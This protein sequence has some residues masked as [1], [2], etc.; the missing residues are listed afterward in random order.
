[1]KKIL[2]S[3]LGLLCLCVIGYVSLNRQETTIVKENLAHVSVKNTHKQHLLS[4]PFSEV[5]KLSKKE[6]KAQGLP[7]NKYLERE[8]EL[9]MNPEIGRP[10]PENLGEI[11]KQIND[12][13]LEGNLQ[14]RVSGDGSDNNWVE[15][16]PDNVGGRTRAVMFDPNDA[17]NETVFAGGVSGGLWKNTNISSASSVWTQVSISENLNVS[18]IV[19]DPID[20]DIF[21]IG[22][23][24][25]YVGGDANGNGVWKSIDQ[26][27][28]W[29][30]VLGGITGATT[31]QAASVVTVNS[32]VGI[33]A[34]YAC[35]P[36][37]VANFGVAFTGTIPG[38]IVLVD[39]GN[40]PNEDACTA[41]T[42]GSLTGKIALI[43]RGTCAFVIKVKAAQEAGA[44]GAI[45]MNNISGTPIPMGGT[46]ATII[47]P[48]VMISK[49]DGDILEA[50]MAGG[51]VTVT[52]ALNEPSGDYTGN[53]V[54]GIQHI[55]DIVIR[56]NGGVSEI[57][58]AAGATYYS[59]ANAYMGGNTYGLYKSVDA[60]ANWTLLSMPL[61]VP[62]GKKHTPND[63]EIGADNRLWIGTTNTT[64]TGEGGGK[65]FVS[66]DAA[67]TTFEEK[68]AITN[69]AR[70]QI[71]TSP[72]NGGTVYVLAQVN[73]IN[74]AGT[75]Y[76]APF[77]NMVK[78]SN[79]FGSTT[80]MALPNG[81]STDA[82]DFTRGQAFYDLVIAV[83]PTNENN[84][85]VGG[86]DLFKSTNAGGSWSQFSSWYGGGF[87][88]V[89]SDQHAFAFGNGDVNKMLIGNDGGV[90]YSA[91]K[92]T[93]TAA[94]NSGFNVTQ[95]YTVGV[96]PSGASAGD[97]FSAG[98]QD[99]GT[100]QFDNVGPGIN[101]SSE[102]QGGDGAGTDY[103]QDSGNYYISNYVYN[104]NIVQRNLSG[105]SLKQLNSASD[106]RGDFIN[107]QDLDSN[108]NLLY[109]NY[110]D[111]GATTPVYQIRR[112]KLANGFGQKVDLSDVLFTSSP[113]ALKVS[114]HTTG[115]TKLFVGTVLGDLLKVSNANGS[116]D[117]WLEIGSDQ[118]VGS[119]SDIEFGATEDDIFVTMHNY[120]VESIWYTKNG[121]ATWQT[122]E[123]NLPDMPVK[124]ILQNPLNP[125]EV[126]IGTE[127]G[128]WYTNDFSSL[129]PSWSSAFNGMSNVKVTDLD[130]RDDNAIYASTYGRGVFSGLFT[131]ESLGVN[132]S[133]V[134]CLQG[135]A[136][137]PNSG[138]ETLM[139]DDLRV[140][141]IIP[142]TSPYTDALTCDTSVFTTTG[143][144]AIVDWIWV[145]LRDATSNTTVL[146]SQSALLQRDGD[147]VG[148]DGIAA[149][150]F[151]AVS[152]DYYIAITHRNHLGVMSSST[153]ALSSNPVTVDFTDSANQITYGSN[154][155]T[156]FGMSSGVVAMWSGDANGDN[157]VQYSGATPDSP[158]ILSYA[159]N[160]AGNF[161]NLPTFLVN[162]YSLNDVDMNGSAQYSGATPDTPFILQNA[163][164]HPGN[165]LNLSTY[166]ITEQ[167][168]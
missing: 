117:T 23:G 35:Y 95:F 37:S 64:T 123:G 2:L 39:D 32:P 158:T 30:K 130:L 13:R 75:Q 141:G 56:N 142:T 121:G 140:A 19:V 132:L 165:F 138:E 146:H 41:L 154:A 60:G 34:D 139:R 98:A 12:L 124:C 58:V 59:T 89:H 108:L 116:S 99:N 79:S 27:T 66:T 78:T 77:L 111:R 128:V 7:P 54:P 10:T 122:K 25:S 109:T 137:N 152:G 49:E 1:M 38:E 133:A 155:Q 87:Q 6:R 84:L 82:N 97:S 61:T 125:E 62:N 145:E 4:S 162:G 102:S 112:Y 163:L 55:N 43:R 15:R 134:V 129:S 53:L 100:Q 18:S 46:D 21:Y 88:Y 74:A 11:K 113:T 110:S 85:F 157:I 70:V 105:G 92:G 45:V 63:L 144:D 5:S 149:L 147:I 33:A 24:E 20:D 36:T 103:D 104:N 161:L 44:I 166:S 28:T 115:S 96:A 14:G 101:G 119:I 114:P 71:A 106:D 167:L 91:N 8:W 16:G 50:A 80:P 168:P 107:Q 143:N 127:L 93:T 72:T 136:L 73:T 156:A 57:Y 94:R 135:A 40:A 52:G 131:A 90:F 83:D 31:F 151:N 118:F 42:P 86:I 160:D 126:I 22:T 17:T 159:L 76:E 26:G 3:A 69:G 51:A 148:V 48:S 29:S 47:I 150:S 9:T 81:N 67:A 68:Y 164:S 120:G 153:V 65:V